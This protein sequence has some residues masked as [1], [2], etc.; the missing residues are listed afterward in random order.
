MRRLVP[1]LL[2]VA[3]ACISA[4][5]DPE[6]TPP[7]EPERTAEAEPPCEAPEVRRVVQRLGERLKHVPLLAPDSVVVRA[8]RETYAPLVTADLLA[9]WTAEPERAPGQDVSS[10]WP[11][12]IDGHTVG[13]GDAIR[14]DPAAAVEFARERSI[15]ILPLCP[16]AKSVFERVPELQDVL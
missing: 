10:P 2:F 14:A 9:A 6:P 3:G 16:F 11:E 12:R 15:R 5:A 7:A 4:C 8:I 13:I 1:L